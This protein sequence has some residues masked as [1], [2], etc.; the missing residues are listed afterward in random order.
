MTIKE[1]I[2]ANCQ[3]NLRKDRAVATGI[4]LFAAVI[5][6]VGEILLRNRAEKGS[7][8]GEDLS[9]KWE[10]PG[11]G[12]D[13]LDFPRDPKNYQGV[14]FKTL[15]RELRE[16]T[17]MEL[18]NLFQPNLWPAWLYK[19]GLIDLAF[20]TV[21]SWN[22]VMETEKFAD[23]LSAGEIGLFSMKY[24]MEKDNYPNIISPRMR[25]LV[26][27]AIN[28]VYCQRGLCD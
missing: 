6:P 23:K 3:E 18:I 1:K 27:E 11:G 28:S 10:L 21:V 2:L 13:L 25:S 14:I 12:V 24:I 8:Y 16:E 20:V 5:N 7:L 4:G 9:G 19:D 15:E 26:K 17:G 22:E